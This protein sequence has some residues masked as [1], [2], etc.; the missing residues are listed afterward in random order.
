MLTKQI[1]FAATIALF[2]PVAGCATEDGGDGSSTLTVENHSS[3]SLIEMNLS[4]TTSISWGADL[5]GTDVLEPGDV[6]HFSGVDC[7]TYD[8][9]I[10]DETNDACILDSVDLCLSNA[11]WSIDDA[12][13][14][15]CGF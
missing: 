4:P 8:I 10:V 2:L 7:G 3:V 11:V 5:L 12:E 9:R 14:V 15:A 6:V 1:L 13:L